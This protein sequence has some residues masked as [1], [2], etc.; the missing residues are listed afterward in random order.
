MSVC[1]YSQNN[2]LLSV[3]L[4]STTNTKSIKCA[5]PCTHDILITL[6]CFSVLLMVINL[7]KVQSLFGIIQCDI[8]RNIWPGVN[9]SLSCCGTV[10]EEIL[11]MILIS[12]LDWSNQVLWWISSPGFWNGLEVCSV[13]RPRLCATGNR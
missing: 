13:A 5:L 4:S 10:M 12:A 7:Y 11:Y 8:T 6:I 2:S 3:S 1:S 9:L